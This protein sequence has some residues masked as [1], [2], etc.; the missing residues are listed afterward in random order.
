MSLRYYGIFQV[1]KWTL[2]DDSCSILFIW[3]LKKLFAISL[4]WVKN[5]YEF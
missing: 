2:L 3:A 1:K 5:N 4:L